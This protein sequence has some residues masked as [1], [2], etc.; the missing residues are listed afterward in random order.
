MSTVAT[1]ILI[2]VVVL[3]VVAIVAAVAAMRARRRR[4]LREQF[5]PEYDRT[6]SGASNRREA[7]RDLQQRAAKHEQLDVR[8]LD[9]ASAQRYRDEWE[10]AQARFVDA[11]AESVA[12][13]HGL[14][15]S[16]LRDRGYPTTDDDE[17]MSMLSVDH[18]DVMDHYR[19]GIRTTEQWRTS[20]S[21]DTEDLRRAMQHYREVFDRVVVTDDSAYPD[22]SPSGTTT[23]E[24]TTTRRR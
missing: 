12:Q 2:A 22:E 10:V 7:E 9:P 20:G 23:T 4:A 17:R 14:V 15:T 19:S 24:G 1:V 5:G 18:A 21:A 11:P 6:V 16:V 8:P 3:V 13:A